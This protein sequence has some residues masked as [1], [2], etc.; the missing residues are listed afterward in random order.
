MSHKR[1][2]H[3]AAPKVNSSAIT[4]TQ[5]LSLSIQAYEA[6]I[7]RGSQSISTALSLEAPDASPL[8]VSDANEPQIGSALIQWGSTRNLQPLNSDSSFPTKATW[9]DRWVSQYGH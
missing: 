4:T 6:T 7:I 1:K 5:N 3:S 2:Y 8:R 9:M